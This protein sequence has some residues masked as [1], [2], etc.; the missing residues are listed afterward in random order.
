MYFASSVFLTKG[1]LNFNKIFFFFLMKYCSNNFIFI[2]IEKEKKR[3]EGYNCLRYATSPQ[4]V[5]QI[6]DFPN[7]L[8][9]VKPK[10][11]KIRN[12]GVS[13]QRSVAGDPA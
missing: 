11:R 10:K 9:L 13:A 2:G 5:L 8:K 3:K 4:Q 12:V 1:L 6:E 7:S